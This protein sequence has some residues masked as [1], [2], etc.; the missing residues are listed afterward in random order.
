MS[1]LGRH[2]RSY[3]D[4]DDDCDDDDDGGG[5]RR[6]GDGAGHRCKKNIFT[7]FLLLSRSLRFL[8]F[9]GQRFLFCFYFCKFCCLTLRIT[10]SI[11]Q[12]GLN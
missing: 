6:G 2:L 3:I 1:L 9:F 7:F 10:C 12:T 4:D 8:T 5:G 11:L